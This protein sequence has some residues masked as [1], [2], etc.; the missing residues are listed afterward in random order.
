MILDLD[1]HP[2]AEKSLEDLRLSL[3]DITARELKYSSVSEMINEHLWVTLVKVAL[4][5]FPP[6]VLSEAIRQHQEEFDKRAEAKL[7]QNRVAAEIAKRETEEAAATAR[8]LTA[9]AN[10][11]RQAAE[12]AKAEA[13]AAHAAAMVE[14]ENAR[15]ATAEANFLRQRAEDE[16]TAVEPPPIVDFLPEMSANDVISTSILKPE[17]LTIW[18]KT[19]KFLGIPMFGIHL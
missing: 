8:R 19:K 17:K 2:D 15:Q 18:E 4:E 11:A 6:A 3:F 14:V 10:L 9:E 13:E 7:K 16:K 1:I 5:R 12:K